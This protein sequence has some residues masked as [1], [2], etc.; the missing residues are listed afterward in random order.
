MPKNL[1]SLMDEYVKKFN[2]PV[3]FGLTMDEKEL[4]TEIEKRLSSGT[5]FKQDFQY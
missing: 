2:E 1:E 4:A 3:P 5:P